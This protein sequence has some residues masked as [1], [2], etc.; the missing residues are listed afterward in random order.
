MSSLLRGDAPVGIEVGQ[1]LDK[2]ELLERVGQGGMAVVYRGLDRNL[3]RTVAVKVLHR[4]LA[5]HKEARQRF[6]REAHAV[7]KLRHENI[8]E[9]F[10]YSGK[11]S[12]DSYIVTEVIRGRPLPAFIAAHHIGFPEI[13]A[14]VVV[15]VCRALQHAH[16]L[17]VL[18]R[19]VKPE[20]IMI[21]DDGVLKLMDF[22]IA[23][24]VDS[25]RMTVTGQLLGSPA[26]MSPEHVE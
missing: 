18:H 1:V 6:E 22:G 14:M 4:H 25:Q 11:G 12:S 17:G 9:I 23:Q 26:Y 5:D 24:I 2:Y 21:R 13:A 16:S 3:R 19:D 15:E 7:A 8:L 10:D 20:N